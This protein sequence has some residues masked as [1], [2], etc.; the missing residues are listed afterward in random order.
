VKYAEVVLSLV[1]AHTPYEKI[2]PASKGMIFLT[3]IGCIVLIYYGVKGILYRSPN[4]KEKLPLWRRVV[5]VL[6]TLFTLMTCLAILVFF[7]AYIFLFVEYGKY[8]SVV[9]KSDTL[10]KAMES[11]DDSKRVIFKAFYTRSSR[12][13]VKEFIRL[14][15]GH[16]HVFLPA[17]NSQASHPV[18]AHTSMFE[19]D[20]NDGYG[21][22]QSKT[23]ATIKDA[24]NSSHGGTFG[25]YIAPSQT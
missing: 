22:L 11:L 21:E 16:E 23:I 1:D 20:S 4:T 25:I 13:L 24:V 9:A 14:P 7:T 6:L 18:H 5:Q 19:R 3:G 8:A 12:F 17:V 15:P 2:H 10:C